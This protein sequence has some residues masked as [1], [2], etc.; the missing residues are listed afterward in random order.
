MP[1]SRRRRRS[2]FAGCGIWVWNA[3]EF[4]PGALVASLARRKFTYL[5]VKG[6]DGDS[7][8]RRNDPLLEAYAEAAR[9]HG[10]RFGVWGYLRGER[11]AA[12]AKLASE[13]V[14]RLKADC[15]V[16]NA[17]VEYERNRTAS[18]R[19]AAAFRRRQSRLPAALSSFGR[20]DYH[21]GLDWKAWHRH[22]FD[23]HPQAYFG[24]NS[25]LHPYACLRA[26]GEVWPAK[27]IRPTLGAYKGA[28]ARPTAAELLESLRGLEFTGFDV[29]RAGSATDA[30]LAALGQLSE[31]P[32]SVIPM[33]PL[34]VTSPWIEGPDVRLLQE[35]VN[36][37]RRRH[38]LVQI[39]VDGQY[40]PETHHAARETAWYLGLGV[41]RAGPYA[42]SVP[43]QRLIA[44]PAKRTDEQ[45]ARGVE[46]RKELRQRGARAALAFARSHLLHEENPIGS[47][48]S[49]LI[50]RWGR[51]YGSPQRKGQPGWPWCG[52]FVGA[53]LRAGGLVVP[54]GII[55][56]PTGLGWARAG[57]NG[58][59]KGLIPPAEARPGDLVYF[60]F[61]TADPEP[62]DHVG[63]VERNLG[64][65][66]LQT[67][68]GNT[69][70]DRNARHPAYGV[71]RRSRSP[72][73][74]VGCAR[75]RWRR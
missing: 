11:P 3:D 41:R 2:P 10:L 71:F 14:D 26:A 19:F 66:R 21:A 73:T 45:K 30:D 35:A 42:L 24:E 6:H 55:Y 1:A 18:R 39:E 68:E 58:F 54:D 4:R 12:E 48:R 67:L 5:L 20:I 23:F 49:R 33:R 36:R 9:R 37:F 64:G 56:T 22:G 74:I 8:F 69:R 32:P 46:R 70:P 63:L 72:G 29:W 62:A 50:D 59:Q 38:K 57:T 15:Y 17:E 60:D 40:G 43:S 51:P 75:P 52:V 27:A 61:D 16:A 13:L 65:G 44:E 7:L 34:S 53:C 47:N 31:G 28:V 25:K